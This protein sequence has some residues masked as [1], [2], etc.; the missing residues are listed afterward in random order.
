MPNRY[1]VLR[2][3]TYHYRR[4]IPLDVQPFLARQQWWKASLKT[5]HVRRAELKARQLAIRHDQLI[6]EIRGTPNREKLIALEKIDDDYFASEEGPVGRFSDAHMCVSHAALKLSNAVFD[7]M[8]AGAAKRLALLTPAERDAVNAA[9]GIEGFFRAA[10]DEHAKLGGAADEIEKEVRTKRLLLKQATLTKLGFQQPILPMPDDPNDPCVSVAEGKWF[11]ARKQGESAINRHRV[12]IRRF[13]EL[14]GDLPVKE[15]N[16]QMVRGYLARIENLADHR[17]LPAPLRGGLADPGADVPR[18]SAPT[19]ERHLT[20]LKAFLQ[21]CC[22]QGW[23]FSNVASGLRPPK[24]GRP[25]ASRRRSFS[26]EERVQ[27]LGRAVAEYGENSDMTWLIKLGAYTGCRLE[28]LAQLARTNVR[29]VDGTWIV[30]ID[31]L[32]GRHVKSL[33]SVKQIPLHPAIRDDFVEWVKKER[34]ER[35][36]ASFKAERGRYSSRLSGEFARLMDRAGL[37]DPRLCFHSLRHSLKRE[38]SNA[39]IDPD[40]RRVILGH[41]PKDAHDE[42]E[43]HSLQAVA[44]ELSRL[45]PLF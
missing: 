36:F 33:A 15:I 10:S 45:P 37:P 26:R 24:D 39:R 43:G 21:F 29:T 25:K 30:E 42:Y 27:L 17:K 4:R 23:V 16:R 40:V 8:V 34:G 18:V 1:L 7:E 41:A 28:E 19:V 13:I 14:H 38:M 22:E 2:Q 11:A 32:D 35:V 12:A 3:T 9:G 5:G 20:S 6:D 44:E 31:D